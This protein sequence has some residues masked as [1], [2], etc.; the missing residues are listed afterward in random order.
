MHLSSVKDNACDLSSGSLGEASV[1][2]NIIGWHLA[3]R[4]RKVPDRHHRHHPHKALFISY[5]NT[6][7]SVVLVSGPPSGI[8]KGRRENKVS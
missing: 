4:D 2:V 8:V 1:K 7:M 5:L 3:D 6:F